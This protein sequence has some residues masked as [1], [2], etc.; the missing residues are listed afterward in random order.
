M[1]KEYVRE[2]LYKHVDKKYRE[3]H[4]KLI[5]NICHEKTLGVRIPQLRMI[6]KQMI[7]DNLW[8]EYLMATPEYM[9]EIMIQGI[10][11]GHVKIPLNERLDY[12]TSFIPL[13]KNWAVC[14]TFCCTMKLK[15]IEKDE[16]WNYLQPYFHSD[17]TYDIRVAVVM[18][19]ANF[20]ESDYTEKAFV[21]FNQIES[22]EYYV[23]MAIAWAIS[24]YFIKNRD[25]TLEYLL[26]NNL[27]NFTHNKAIQK[28]R[29]SF[30]VSA[31][32][33]NYVNTLKRK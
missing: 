17:Q 27:D 10:I 15:G 4:I 11:I 18:G 13:I 9:E 26:N 22:H 25:I 5:P 20:T 14:D 23:Q 2:Q 7:K 3:F 21:L 28:I 8:R 12:M 16:L 1:P 33:K 6:A 31:K 24:V 32:D 29:E 30:R 19:L